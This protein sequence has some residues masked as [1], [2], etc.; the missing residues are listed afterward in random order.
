MPTQTENNNK[1]YDSSL[2]DAE[3]RNKNKVN[4]DSL[5]DKEKEIQGNQEAP[6]ETSRL[7]QY[8]NN[9]KLTLQRNPKKS[10]GLG[11]GLL[12]LL[13]AVYVG[14]LSLGPLEVINLSENLKLTF[15]SDHEDA[16]SSRAT[17]LFFYAKS[18]GDYSRTRLGV[19]GNLHASSIDRKLAAK[20]V[21]VKYTNGT[22]F[23]YVFDATKG[24]PKLS[25]KEALKE[26]KA[27]QAAAEREGVKG[28]IEGHTFVAESDGKILKTKNDRFLHKYMMRNVL[29]NGKTYTALA[30]RTQNKRSAL[31]KWNVLAR[32]DAKV[33]EKRSALLKNLKDR[34]VGKKNSLSAE[35]TKAADDASEAEKATAKSTQSTAESA[36]T[37]SEEIKTGKS[38]AA[39]FLGAGKIAGGAGVAG[40]GLL[41]MV[42]AA[43][44]DI[45]GTNRIVAKTTVINAFHVFLPLGDEAKSGDYSIINFQ[46][47]GEIAKMLR[48]DPD[49]KAQAQKNGQVV[50]ESSAIQNY[51]NSKQTDRVDSSGAKLPD[52]IRQD[53]TDSSVG[54]FL[55]SVPGLDPICKAATSSVALI[56]GIVTGPVTTAVTA[57]ATPVL[58]DKVTS[59]FKN[60]VIDLTEK[61]YHGGVLKEA[62]YAGGREYSNQ[63]WYQDGGRPLTDNE[64]AIENNIEKV[65]RI[66][67]N[68]NRSFKE[69]Y[70]DIYESRSVA[71]NVATSLSNQSFSSIPDRLVG[72]F[73]SILSQKLLPKTGASS[74]ATDTAMYYGT[75]KAK[76]TTAF[77][78]KYEQPYETSEQARQIL[79]GPEGDKYKKL[80]EK[81]FNQTVVVSEDNL[82]FKSIDG[83]QSDPKLI[84]PDKKEYP[85]ECK[86]DNDENLNKIKDALFSL[87]SM[88]RI[89][90]YEFDDPVSCSEVMPGSEENEGTTSEGGAFIQG[91]YAWPIG[92]YKKDVVAGAPLPC[93]SRSCHWDGSPAFD[94]SNK[95]NDKTPGTPVYAIT[96]GTMNL[97]KEKRAQ[98]W[99]FHIA[100]KD[101]YDYFYGHVNKPIIKSGSKKVN[102]GDLVAEIGSVSCG[103][104]ISHLHIDQSKELYHQPA[105]RTE[106]LNKII[107]DLYE[108]LPDTAPAISENADNWNWPLKTDIKINSC[109][110]QPLSK[111]PHPGLDFYATMN[112][113][114]YAAAS[115]TVVGQLGGSYGTI[116]IK[117]GEKLYSVYE[118]LSSIEVKKG[119]EVNVG[120]KIGESG[121]TGAPGA[122]H[123]HFGV[124][125]DVNVYAYAQMGEGKIINPLKYLNNNKDFKQCSASPA[126]K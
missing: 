83:D 101:G 28:K 56:V 45:D 54:K 77:Q 90:C 23:T 25:E 65:N 84:D 50:Y 85:E 57:L 108:K 51:E 88:K 66:A 107:N 21:T 105:D 91:D 60:D 73:S 36:N 94:L 34:L 44:E 69:K 48:A 97:V 93:Q 115:G 5:S 122:P 67:D 16:S 123:L 125:E 9:A 110:N 40:V 47:L 33:N 39:K 43:V 86:S 2:Y 19:L 121:Q 15:F 99:T 17:K 8:L 75:R 96:D 41:C 109:F 79:M 64:I 20:G 30:T 74:P 81:C 106:N 120:E 62:I 38:T 100:G 113:P 29:D 6:N 37:A 112:T 10:A 59:F 52:Q 26:A 76:I 58:M 22:K 95:V 49:V 70:F 89:S 3:N 124:T 1:I 102:K 111:G 118:H 98:C 4:D 18:G 12:G 126:I 82:D 119:Q 92:I 104:T 13:S 7:S 27:L 61:I 80:M 63:L 114:V 11:F 116:E 68:K 42:K 53:K 103:D 35:G 87:N 32:A 31:A 14:T 55:Q 24:Q 71:N 72:N 46:G 78:D 117:H